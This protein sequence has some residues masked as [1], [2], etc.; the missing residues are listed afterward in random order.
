MKAD[1]KDLL[2]NTGGALVAGVAIK[3]VQSPITPIA[4]L[5]AGVYMALKG[6]GNVK[7]FGQGIATIGAIGTL[8][9]VAEKVEVMQKITPTI[10]GMGDLYEDEDGNLVELGGLNGQ[11]QLVQDED[12]NTYM[13]DG[14]TGEYVA[15]DEDDYDEEPINGLAGNDLQELV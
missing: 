13:I 6:K 4:L 3:K 9:K 12:G 10:N 2:A 11:P 5:G 8:G 15:I 7:N 1:A 14:L